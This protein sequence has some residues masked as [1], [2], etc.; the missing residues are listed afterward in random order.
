[1]F[2]RFLQT[3]VNGLFRARASD[4][5]AEA[6]HSREGLVFRAIEEGLRLAQAEHSGL[7]TR[8]QDV[9]V[10]GAISL[11]NGIDEYLTRGSADTLVQNQFDREIAAGQRR[12]EQLSHQIQA[13]MSLKADFIGRFPDFKSSSAE[14]RRVA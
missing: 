4:R 10:R 2:A 12:L 1:M 6:D 9:L 14:R 7:N 13:F 11:G 3:R 5:D 8:V